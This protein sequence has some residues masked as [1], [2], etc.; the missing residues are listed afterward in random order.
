MYSTRG[1]RSVKFY[2]SPLEAVKD[3]PDGA[4]VLL[5]GF[6]VCGIPEKLIQAL[7]EAG[8]KHLTAVS[9]NSGQPDWGIGRLIRSG[10]VN[11]ILSVIET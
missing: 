1:D 4:K 7:V 5:G 3:I 11:K 10:Q 8:P 2:D 9:N 6:G